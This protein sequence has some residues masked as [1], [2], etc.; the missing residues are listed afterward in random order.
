MAPQRPR[1]RINPVRTP[2]RRPLFRAREIAELLGVS[3]W[4]VYSWTRKGTIPAIR[5][6]D[7][8]LRFDADAVI[9]ALE[10]GRN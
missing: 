10:G 1:P 9:A 6:T 8:I 3:T 7:R 5:A 2:T 4:T